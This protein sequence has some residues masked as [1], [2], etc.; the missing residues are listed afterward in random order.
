MITKDLV[1]Y[2][3]L[4]EFAIGKCRQY[5]VT[6][7]PQLLVFLDDPRKIQR[8]PSPSRAGLLSFTF[9]LT[10][11]LQA[12]SNLGV[13]VQYI[14]PTALPFLHSFALPVAIVGSLN[15]WIE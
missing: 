11:A 2:S 10:Y 13:H 5:R 14:L 7:T 12:Y 3:F 15:D 8:H 4:L 1:A 9:T 6:V